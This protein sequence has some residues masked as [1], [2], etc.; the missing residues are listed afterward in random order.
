MGC[1]G[2]K[3]DEEPIGASASSAPNGSSASGLPGSKVPPSLEQA[4]SDPNLNVAREPRLSVKYQSRE[5]LDASRPLAT[6]AQLPAYAA[7]LF[8][9]NSGAQFGATL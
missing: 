9:R 7:Q 2:S 5:L 4:R 6:D 1:A 3:E 8:R